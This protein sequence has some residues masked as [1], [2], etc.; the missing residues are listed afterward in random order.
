MKDY[1]SFINRRF[2]KLVIS[3]ISGYRKYEHDG[4]I[5]NLPLVNVVCD[6]GNKKVILL[7][8][9]INKKTNSCGCQIG[10][11]NV[12][13]GFANKKEYRTWIHMM[14]RCYKPQ[15]PGYKDYG[16]RGIKV[17]KR[18]HNIKLFVKD[19]WPPPSNKHT[20]DRYPNNN[21]DYKPS[22]FRWA[23]KKEQQNNMRSNR[24]FTIDGKTMNLSE[25]RDLYGISHATLCYRLK[26]GIDIKTA[27]TTPPDKRYIRKQKLLLNNA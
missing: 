21:G 19:T 15:E 11:G 23:T 20:L 25:W 13:H 10:K 3:R 16:G 18:W 22:N 4:K 27:L 8:N 12:I 24:P 17:C 5:R 2:G 26:N 14:N 9:I 1:S 7:N 6:C